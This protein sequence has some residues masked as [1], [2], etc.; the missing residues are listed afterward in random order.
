MSIKKIDKL[1]DRFVIDE[2]NFCG[3]YDSSVITDIIKVF[4]R[5]ATAG[6]N[7][8]YITY[9]CEDLKLDC[10]YVHLILNILDRLGWTEHGTAVRGCWID[11]E[12]GEKIM[13]KYKILF[14]HVKEEYKI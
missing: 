9:L 4:I 13:E 8:R 12:K 3:C 2:L 6:N 11:E 7:R 14:D 1:M 5:L 10:K